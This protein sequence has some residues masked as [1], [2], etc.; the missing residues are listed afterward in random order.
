MEGLAARTGSPAAVAITTAL[1]RVEA[2]RAT[3]AQ[4][5][6]VGSD[7]TTTVIPA[8]SQQAAAKTTF[9]RQSLVFTK[10]EARTITWSQSNSSPQPT[11][12]P[13]NV[14]MPRPKTKERKDPTKVG[15]PPKGEFFLLVFTMNKGNDQ[16][17][18]ESLKSHLEPNNPHGYLFIAHNRRIPNWRAAKH[19]V[20]PDSKKITAAPGVELN[21]RIPT[22]SRVFPPPREPRVT[23]MIWGPEAEDYLR[24]KAAFNCSAPAPTQ[25]SSRGM[26]KEG[27]K[28]AFTSPSL[29]MPPIILRMQPI[30]P[31]IDL[32]NQCIPAPN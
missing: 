23:T 1:H 15:L 29:R 7:G 22:G 8:T 5:F 6:S 24:A 21:P 14:E 27:P 3:R 32:N 30:K 26:E 28:M 10:E 2:A 9:S 31:C 18:G 20:H 4:A 11:S 25:R 16:S 17:L 13:S 19:A 12:L